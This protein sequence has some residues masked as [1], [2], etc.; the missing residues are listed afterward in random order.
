M[1]RLTRDGTAEPVSRDQILGAN[2]DRE[3]FIFCVQLTKSMIGNLT[4]LIHITLAL[5]VTRLYG[6]LYYNV[7]IIFITFNIISMKKRLCQ[8]YS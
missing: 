2:A 4:R 5:C 6:W 7:P 8:R 3:I 1:S